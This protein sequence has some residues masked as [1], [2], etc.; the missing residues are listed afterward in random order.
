LN[1]R[2]TPASY[3]NP[4]ESTNH[5]VIIRVYLVLS[6]HEVILTPCFSSSLNDSG[7]FSLPLPLTFRIAGCYRYDLPSPVPDIA[8]ANIPSPKIAIIMNT[9]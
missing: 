8:H 2:I 3:G 4:S 6:S 9:I 1:R 5:E 7:S